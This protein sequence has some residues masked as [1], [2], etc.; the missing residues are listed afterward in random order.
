MISEKVMRAKFEEKP[1]TRADLMLILFLLWT[2]LY[3]M[4]LVPSLSIFFIVVIRVCDVLILL[5]SSDL[6]PDPESC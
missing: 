3:M 4:S 1:Y 2:T 6:F 5:E